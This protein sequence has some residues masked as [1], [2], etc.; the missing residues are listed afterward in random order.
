MPP[1]L[2]IIRSLL[3]RFNASAR[4]TYLTLRAFGLRLRSVIHTAAPP[5]SQPRRLSLHALTV[6]LLSIL[7]FNIKNYITRNENCQPKFTKRKNRRKVSRRSHKKEKIILM[8]AEQF[9]STLVW[10]D[11]NQSRLRNKILHNTLPQNLKYGSI[12]AF[13][14][15]RLITKFF[16]S[17]G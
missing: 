7:A 8:P 3:I 13:I 17:V 5:T 1:N 15:L 16:V 14:R 9:K 4:R 2:P 11:S 10:Q 12:P 6:L